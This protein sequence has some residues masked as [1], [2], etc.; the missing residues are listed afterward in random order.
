MTP[1]KTRGRP[2]KYNTEQQ[3]LKGLYTSQAK[4]RKNNMMTFSFRFWIN[5]DALVIEKLQNQKNKTDYIRQLII[6]DIKKPKN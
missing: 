6:E 1:A 4:Y 5:K 2:K 3:V